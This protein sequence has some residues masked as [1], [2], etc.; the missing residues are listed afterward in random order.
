MEPKRPGSLQDLFNDKMR[1][2][3]EALGLTGAALESKLEYE[4]KVVPQQVLDDLRHEYQT[5]MR[6][7]KDDV[8]RHKVKARK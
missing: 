7:Y 8:A 5:L 4:W 6:R 2:E 1:P 3:F